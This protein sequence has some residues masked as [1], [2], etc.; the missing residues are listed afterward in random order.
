MPIKRLL[1]KLRSQQSDS[2]KNEET[3]PTDLYQE[4]GIEIL[5]GVQDQNADCTQPKKLWDVAFESG[6]YNR[7]RK[8]PETAIEFLIITER[9]P[10]WHYQKYLHRADDDD[11]IISLVALSALINDVL[12]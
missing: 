8:N 7:L 10:T 1:D 3:R 12:H 11:D 4:M 6:L 9:G 2:Q 5:D